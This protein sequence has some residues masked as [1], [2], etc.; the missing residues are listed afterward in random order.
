M[1]TME[2]MQIYYYFILSVAWA[3]PEQYDLMSSWSTCRPPL[4]STYSSAY[5][6]THTLQNMQDVNFINN[7]MFEYCP[8]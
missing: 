4:F 3:K 6:F 1:V 2:L 7:C 5:K 8:E